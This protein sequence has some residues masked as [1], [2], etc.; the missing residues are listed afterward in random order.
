[1]LLNLMQSNGIFCE[2][3]DFMHIVKKGKF[4][5]SKE[6]GLRL[7]NKQQPKER[8]T[9][10]SNADNTSSHS[11]PCNIS[12][13]SK[14]SRTKPPQNGSETYQGTSI[15]EVQGSLLTHGPNLMVA[16]RQHPHLEYITAIEQMCH[17]LVTKKNSHLPKPNLGM[18]EHKAIQELTRNKNRII[19][20]VDKGWALLEQPTYNFITT[21]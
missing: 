7:Y 15:L 11:N 1:M 20:R 8:D 5:K 16:P 19:L 10:C 3:K 6:P 14:D 4:W 2:S 18:A 21:D 12:D 17:S 13:H 9:D